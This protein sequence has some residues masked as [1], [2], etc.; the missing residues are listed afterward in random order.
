[1]MEDGIIRDIAFNI[2]IVG[3][4]STLFVNGNPLLRFD[5]YHV[6]S[7]AIEVPNLASRSSK[8]LGY[9]C[10][11]LL[12]GLDDLISPVTAQG[13]SRWL[14]FYGLVAGIYRLFISFTIAFFVASH[15]FIIGVLLAL[16]SLVQQII[17]PTIV[18]LKNLLLMA[19]AR[20]RLYRLTATS[21]PIVLIFMLLLFSQPHFSTNIEGM[22]VLPETGLIR[23]KSDGFVE[24]IF[25]EN[26]Q[27]VNQGD[28]L[29]ELVNPELTVQEA[30][31]KAQIEELKDEKAMRFQKGRWLVR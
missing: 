13:E 18:A 7:D 20:A 29:F 21:V 25:K 16:L 10:Q 17:W 15:Y 19:K 24:R 9:L 3:G 26:G 14:L 30:L 28:V 6:F 31:I 8:Y 22:A 11:R 27:Q 1:M 12:L 5:G 4:L 2:A 23:A